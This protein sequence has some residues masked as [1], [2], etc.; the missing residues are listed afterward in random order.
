VPARWSYGGLA[1]GLGA[2]GAFGVATAAEISGQSGHWLLLAILYGA[3]A[4]AFVPAV[5]ISVVPSPRRQLILRVET[6][7][8]LVLAFGLFAIDPGIA[9]LLTLPT[10][11]LSTSAGL[12]FQGRRAKAD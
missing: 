9:F 3:I 11:L 7:L 10:V 4:A 2:V 8:S 6:A 5:I 1:G 12:I